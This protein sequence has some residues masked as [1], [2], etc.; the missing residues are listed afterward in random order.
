MA[1]GYPRDLTL[2]KFS[3]ASDTNGVDVG[4]LIN[5]GL[6]NRNSTATS[7]PSE[8][9]ISGG[10]AYPAANTGSGPYS[11]TDINVIQKFPFASDTNITDAGDLVRTTVG[12]NGLSARTNGISFQFDVE[13][14]YPQTQISKF[15]FAT[16]SSSASSS[17][18]L[19]A[20][21]QKMGSVSITH[22]YTMGGKQVPPAGDNAIEKFN[23]STEADATDVGDLLYVTYGG[24]GTQSET[25]GFGF[26]GTQPSPYARYNN[27][28]K[29]AFASDG[30]A[31]D[32]GDLTVARQSGLH[33]ANNST[34]GYAAGG[35]FDAFPY[36]SNVIDKFAFASD[37]N[38]TD[39]GDMYAGKDDLSKGQLQ[40]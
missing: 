37:G 36:Y 40:V 9:F 4:D 2:Q 19:N 7:S 10:L 23:F 1:G 32:V 38:A 3:L 5:P 31:T 16:V 15:P 11:T 8:G 18:V 6:H 20:K 13:Y 25:H 17:A 39:V 34:H 29:F 21:G 35:D 26:A 24:G 27:I 28:N 22:G 33:G 12:S 14:P 30:N